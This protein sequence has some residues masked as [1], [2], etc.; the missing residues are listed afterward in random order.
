MRLSCLVACLLVAVGCST[1]TGPI[2]DPAGKGDGDGAGAGA[3]DGAGDDGAGDDG[4]GDDI[5]GGEDDTGGGDDT[6]IPFECPMA[7]LGTVGALLD[8]EAYRIDADAYLYT[9]IDEATEFYVELYD[10]YG[11]FTDAPPAAGTYQ[12]TG[13]DVAYS[14]CGVCVSLVI[15]TETTD[16]VYMATEGS[17]TIESV[18]GNFTGSATGLRFAETEDGDVPTPGGCTG[19]IDDVAFDQPY[20]AAP[21]P[22]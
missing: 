3:G 14:T 12:I 6:P 16:V 4:A 18:D 21:E 19:A 20:G 7:A 11:I 1:A 15:A 17:V 9:T 8:S 5:G 2:G 10:G 13:E 22:I